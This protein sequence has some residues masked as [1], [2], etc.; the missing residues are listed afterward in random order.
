MVTVLTSK[1]V[2]HS[3]GNIQGGGGGGGGQ[4]L[5]LRNDVLT[6]CKAIR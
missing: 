3:L 1:F 2:L 5:G 6:T 4:G